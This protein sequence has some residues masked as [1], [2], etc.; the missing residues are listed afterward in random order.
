MRMDISGTDHCFIE[1]CSADRFRMTVGKT[2]VAAA[3]VPGRG[4]A[5]V[6]SVHG[7]KNI[8]S[9]DGFTLVVTVTNQDL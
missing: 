7:T 2:V 1:F 8:F 5:A 3:A 6:N 4:I 9:T